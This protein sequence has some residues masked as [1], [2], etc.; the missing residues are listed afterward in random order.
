MSA[1]GTGGVPLPRLIEP[2]QQLHHAPEP[3]VP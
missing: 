1:D 2:R 3:T